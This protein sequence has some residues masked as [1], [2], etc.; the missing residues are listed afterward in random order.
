MASKGALSMRVKE[1]VAL[2]CTAGSIFCASSYEKTPIVRLVNS[3]NV[4]FSREKMVTSI[5]A[6]FRRGRFD[7]I[8]SPCDLQ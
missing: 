7:E 1:G 2:K 3:L 4:G 5:K 8:S 6:L